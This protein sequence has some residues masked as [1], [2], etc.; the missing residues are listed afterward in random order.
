MVAERPNLWECF[1]ATRGTP[2]AILRGAFSEYFAA[3]CAERMVQ[4][5]SEAVLTTVQDRGHPLLLDE[6]ES[7]PAILALLERATPKA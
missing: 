4:Q 2:V 5:H 1:L 3:D 7:I 6:P